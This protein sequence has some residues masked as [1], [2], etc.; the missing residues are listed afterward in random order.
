MSE[1]SKR[2]GQ[3][4]E[5]AAVQFEALQRIARLIVETDNLAAALQVAADAAAQTLE[6]RLVIL[7]VSDPDLGL[8][9]VTAG[10][11]SAAGSA[12]LPDAAR[13]AA[14]GTLVAPWAGLPDFTAGDILPSYRWISAP[15]AYCGRPIGQLRAA[16]Q[17]E[18]IPFTD[19]DE[20]F[21]FALA[22]QAGLAC[23][24]DRLRRIESI[25]RR[26]AETL[27]ETAKILNFSLDIQRL[28]GLI[29]DQ[30]GRVVQFD[31]ASVMLVS[32]EQLTIA[33]H[34][35][36][37]L[38]EQLNIPS[39]INAYPHIREVIDL[40][41]PVI[42]PDTYCDPRWLS[43]PEETNIRSWL[44]VPLTGRDTVIGLLNL[45][46]IQPH[47]FTSLDAVLAST[48][49]QQAAIAIENARL[50][51]SERQRADQLNALTA[52][53]ADIS[54][55]LGLARLLEAILER[56]VTLL[57]ATGGEL[58]LY[59]E[60]DGGVNI[61]ASHNLGRDFTGTHLAPGEGAMGRAIQQRQPINIDNYEGWEHASPQYIGTIAQS[62]LTVPFLIGQRVIGA[63]GV[64]DETHS[65]RFSQSDELL[66]SLFAQHAAI[67]VENARLYQTAV[68]AADRRL[69][70]HEVSQAIVG[71]ALQPEEIY[72]AIHTAAARLMP[73]EA[74]VIARFNPASGETSAVYQ[75]DRGQRYP[76]APYTHGLSLF[77]RVLESD[78]SINIADLRNEQ[79]ADFEHFGGDDR[80]VRSV[81]AAPMR[82]RGLVMGMIS[83]QS[84]HPN[85]YTDD[86]RLL[87]EMLASY[88]AI[89]LE[90]ASLFQNVQRL[91]ITD[92]LTGL[93]N[94]RHLFDLGQREFVRARR[95]N[96]P[97]S[98]LMIDID[99][100]KEVNDRYSHS[101]GDRALIRLA[102]V[103]R[104]AI[105]EIDIVGRYGGD[106][107]TVFLPEAELPIAMDIAGR[108]H[109][110]VNLT[111]QH[112]SLP[113]LTI[114]IGAAALIPAHAGFNDLVHAADLALYNAK[115][116]GRNRVSI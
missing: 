62:V 82:L 83:T 69:V 84:Y 23:E 56:A 52:T 6:A 8:S 87:L 21:L 24:A 18:A 67:A 2:G 101:I 5:R 43:L 115:H 68:N 95:F 7:T 92:P 90:N 19:A 22:N 97:L 73:A 29:I 88:A 61:F 27:R 65:R 4:N 70:L 34:R 66:L 36:L 76:S 75:F 28:L 103:L 31:S 63:I 16:R 114:S 59:D 15:L 47:A 94:R 48:F 30:L 77:G 58:G 49:A 116:A 110:Q 44:G 54:S 109:Q 35:G 46:R 81:L 64:S 55:E 79:N 102:Q 33:A 41:R 113:Q 111:F 74:F 80:A 39:Q 112:T 51:D 10:P 60:T 11:E 78:Q 106:E 40:R 1:A 100:F 50:Y 71:A 98:A 13:R 105:R 85:R 89:A 20:R 96:R 17:P 42:I 9:A 53:I 91:A 104:S 26:Q 108:L 14:D 3:S 93:F 86:D 37:R 57:H 38:P 45:D 12:S 32:G 72:T 99:H 25:Q 107:F